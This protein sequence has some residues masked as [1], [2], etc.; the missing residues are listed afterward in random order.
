MH[1]PEISTL[2]Q[3]I[4]KLPG[5]GQ[6]SGRRIALHLLNNKEL[7][8]KNVL[9]ALTQAYDHIKTC[10]VC[11]NLDTT[12]PC[13]ICSSSRRDPKILCIVES[14]ADLWAIE[15]SK[16]YSGYYHVLGGLLS[17]IDGVGPDRLHLHNLQQRIEQG[18]D[19]VILSLSATVDGQT[20]LH[21]IA[22]QL[23]NLPNLKMTT[24][25]H[26]VPIGGELDYLDDGTLTVAFSGRRSIAA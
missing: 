21:F 23:K 11:G 25:S 10:A 13:V 18:V 2:I 8:L 15:R 9:D 22:N 12:S 17:A 7:I 24:L 4:G 19:E 1:S 16:T 20:T 3:L 5:L 26:G 14:V 6:R